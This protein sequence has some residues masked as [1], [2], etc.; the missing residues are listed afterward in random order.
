MKIQTAYLSHVP[1]G[2]KQL[3]EQL[4]DR[5]T[6]LLAKSETDLGPTDLVKMKIDT[7]ITILSNSCHAVS[8][9]VNV[10]W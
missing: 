3:I 7:G 2:Q 1:E 4:I 9:S 6:D 8:N 10:R 5:N